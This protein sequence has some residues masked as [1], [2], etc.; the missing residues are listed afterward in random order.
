MFNS[1]CQKTKTHFQCSIIEIQMSKLS[2]QIQQESSCIFPQGIFFLWLQSSNL[3][4]REVVT[5]CVSGL[6][7][8][9]LQMLCFICHM[10]QF[11][12]WFCCLSKQNSKPFWPQ[13]PVLWENKVV[14]TFWTFGVPESNSVFPTVCDSTLEACMDPT[15][16]QAWQFLHFS[17]SDCGRLGFAGV[18]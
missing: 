12:P 2:P 10:T 4:T 17:W 11:V 13:T 1:W 3:G 5:L 6:S 18:G 7:R 15:P 9:V 8:S 16:K 14:K